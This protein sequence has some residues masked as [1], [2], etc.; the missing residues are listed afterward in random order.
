VAKHNGVLWI[1][2]SKATNPHAAAAS[3]SAFDPVVWIAGG[4]S[5][6]VSYD[7]LVR[8]HSRR[9]KAVVLIGR[10]TAALEESLQ[11]HAPDVPVIRPATGD[12]EN[13]QSAGTG[14]DAAQLSSESGGAVMALAVA[15]AAQLATSGDT[16]L[17]A[18]AAASMDQFSSY[19]HR[20]DAFIEAVR[21][22]VEGQAQTGKE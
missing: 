2:D 15:S 19:A 8:D 3:L 13:V 14:H 17:M 1:N 22:L 20:G 5:K 9:L 18:P 7:E 10:D 21:E 11:R 12:T 16:V 4:L 6:G